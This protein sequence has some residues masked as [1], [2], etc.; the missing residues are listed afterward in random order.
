MDTRN[1]ILVPDGFYHIYNRGI[2]SAKIFTTHE[3]YL[4]FLSKFAAYVSPLCDVYAYCLMPNHF[5]FVIKVKSE[6]EL[7]AYAILSNRDLAK[8]DLNKKGL[9]SFDSIVS[10]QIGKFISSYSQAYNKINKRHGA[11]LE[12]PFKRKRIESEEYL[13]NLILY[14][15]LNPIG[16]KIDYASYF[17][18]SYKGILSTQATL[19]KREETILLFDTIENFIYLH[20]CPPKN[21]FNF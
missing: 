5:H 14:I 4:F 12:S 7:R 10:K 19:L 1:E 16:F 15:H 3:N 6:E 13:R 18:S 9:H 2:N 17:Y 11:L 20:Q 21:E 8:I